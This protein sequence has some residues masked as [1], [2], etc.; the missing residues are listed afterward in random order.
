[1]QTTTASSIS[2]AQTS[3]RRLISRRPIRLRYRI[4]GMVAAMLVLPL[5]TVLSM[6]M[7][8]TMYSRQ[9]AA[10]PE[11]SK[12]KEA[13]RVHDHVAT[14]PPNFRVERLEAIDTY[15]NGTFRDVYHDPARMRSIFG[16]T[17]FGGFRDGQLESFFS[18][19]VPSPQNLD[20]ARRD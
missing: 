10:M 5:F 1:M 19:P 2:E 13:I 16:Q 18:A 17:H 14:G 9:E 7:I 20:I 12:F 15:I 8:S 4:A 6:L 11:I 3:I